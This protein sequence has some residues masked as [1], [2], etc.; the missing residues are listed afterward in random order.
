MSALTLKADIISSSY[1]PRRIVPLA[2]GTPS[3]TCPSADLIHCPLPAV[4]L[5][6]TRNS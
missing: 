1:G 5:A 3:Q 2:I 4:R 6:L